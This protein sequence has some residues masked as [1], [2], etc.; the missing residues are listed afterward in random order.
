MSKDDV[1]RDLAQLRAEVA[2][3]S[4]ARKESAAT[5]T[6]SGPPPPV[7]D[8]TSSTQ[9]GA[10][11]ETGV[12]GATEA[13]EPEHSQLDELLELLEAE[14]KDLPTIT[15]LIVFSLGILMGRFLR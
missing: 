11:P 7:A 3:L 8:A 12:A 5:P 9:T 1:E 15:C 13:A 2:A 4:A 10:E 14:I 6:A